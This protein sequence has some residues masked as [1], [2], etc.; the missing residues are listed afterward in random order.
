[1]N[2]ARIPAGYHEAV[3]TVND[4]ADSTVG[5]RRC[6]PFVVRRGA[7]SLSA[8]LVGRPVQVYGNPT[9]VLLKPR[10]IAQ[11]LAFHDRHLVGRQTIGAD[12]GSRLLTIDT[13]QLGL[14]PV[15]LTLLGLTGDGNNVTCRP[16]W[17]TVVPDQP[18]PAQHVSVGEPIAPLVLR[19]TTSAT[20][21]TIESTENMAW[22]GKA[23]VQN[24]EPFTLTARVQAQTTGVYQVQSVFK[25]NLTVRLDDNVVMTESHPGYMRA[26][27]PICLERGTHELFVSGRLDDV[28]LFELR[29]GHL[30]AARIGRTGTTR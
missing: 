18:M 3:V 19:G 7:A 21:Q 14:G 30:G 6:V 12:E 4:D 22:L 24:G 9:S 13:R 29:F 2:T 26:E 15:E 17:L 16:L 1:M 10:G 20:P 5:G 8:E 11:V 28:S 27:V 23:G 25:G